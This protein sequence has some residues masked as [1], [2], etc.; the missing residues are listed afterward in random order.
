MNCQSCGN[1]VNVAT[2]H[3]CNLCGPKDR[4][5]TDTI[6]GP[7]YIKKAVLVDK[8]F[9]DQAFIENKKLKCANFLMKLF[10]RKN[11]FSSYGSKKKTL[12][13]CFGAA[14]YCAYGKCKG[15]KKPVGDGQE[16]TEIFRCTMRI[17]ETLDGRFEI[18]LI[19]SQTDAPCECIDID[20][21]KIWRLNQLHLDIPEEDD[22]NDD[23]EEDD[24]DDDDNN[25]T[26]V[27]EQSQAAA[28]ESKTVKEEEEEAKEIAEKFK[29]MKLEKN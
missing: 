14:I 8:G 7:I 18:I 4:Q 17:H 19:S 22:D 27:Q 5:P 9:Y 26:E 25:F 3:L 2:I 12:K 16:Q 6:K 21:D 1:E 20:T 10:S 24:D 15:H 29:G 23:G 11:K 28:G 13:R